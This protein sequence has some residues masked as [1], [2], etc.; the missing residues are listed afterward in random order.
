MSARFGKA[1]PS[2]LT[3]VSASTS[4]PS[5]YPHR[6]TETE[7]VCSVSSSGSEWKVVC[8]VSDS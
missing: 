5:A 6:G 7:V 2:L 4:T 8:F 1:D 3:K